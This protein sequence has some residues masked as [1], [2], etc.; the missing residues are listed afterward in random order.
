[1]TTG[2][3]VPRFFFLFPRTEH[4]RAHLKVF[5]F[6]IVVTDTGPN[7]IG[8]GTKTRIEKNDQSLYSTKTSRPFS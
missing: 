6:F 1:M 5:G 8:C 4:V 7:V 3:I 2:V